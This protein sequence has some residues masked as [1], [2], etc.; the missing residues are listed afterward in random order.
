M[1][2]LNGMALDLADE[3][4]RRGAVDRELDD[5]AGRGDLCQELLDVARDEGERLRLAAV[6]VDDRR[7]LLPA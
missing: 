2:R 6:A 3:R 5:R 7:E 1:L 4:A